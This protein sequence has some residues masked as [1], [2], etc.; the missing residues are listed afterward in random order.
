MLLRHANTYAT[1]KRLT[2]YDYDNCQMK[3]YGE[4]NYPL[5]LKNRII[6]M[7]K[8]THFEIYDLKIYL[9]CFVLNRKTTKMKLL[10]ENNRQL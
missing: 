10:H 6:L 4:T 1:R 9:N 5:L 2:D 3:I 8:R 7:R